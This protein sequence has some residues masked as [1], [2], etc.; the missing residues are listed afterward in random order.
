[1]RYRRAPAR[2]GAARGE[3]RQEV[4]EMRMD[5]GGRGCGGE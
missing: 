3:R 1:M 2:G 4:C 5:K